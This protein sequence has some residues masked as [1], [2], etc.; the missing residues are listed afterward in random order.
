MQKI[1]ALNATASETAVKIMPQLYQLPIV[2][3][4]KIKEW[5]GFTR[6]GAN[7]TIHRF[8]DLGIL[9]PYNEEDKYKRSFI[10]KDYLKI[11]TD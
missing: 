5:T 1:Q 4:A 2:N 9:Y 11:F 10:Y 3:V 8:I 6:Q 7:K